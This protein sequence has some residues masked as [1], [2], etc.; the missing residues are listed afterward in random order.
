M[1]KIALLLLLVS[2]GGIIL[3]EQD[4]VNVIM[5]TNYGD[6]YLELYP[7]IAPTTVEN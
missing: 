7:K 6:I 2:L 5:K 3:A 1:K 4:V